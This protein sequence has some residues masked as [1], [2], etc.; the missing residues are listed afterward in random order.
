V[1]QLGQSK[2]KGTAKAKELPNIDAD[3]AVRRAVTYLKTAPVATEGD[4]GD[5]T[6]YKVACKLKDFGVGMVTAY[7]LMMGDWNSRCNPP[8]G[9]ELWEKIKH[10]YLYGQEPQGAAAPEAQFPPIEEPDQPEALHPF[11]K[12]NKE[13]A[14]VKKGAFVL[15]ETTDDTGAFVTEHLNMAEFHGWFA[16]KMFAA[17]NAKPKPI[18]ECWLSWAQRR[19]YEA[20]VFRPQEDVGPRWYNL[21]RGFSVEPAEHSDH[22]SVA[23]FKE[24][25]LNNV[26][27]GDEE[28]CHWLLGYF[29]HM[30]QKPWEKPL[31]A[32]VFKGKKGTGKNA[33]VERVGQLFSSH[34][35]VADD[36]RYLLSNFNSHLESN[37]FFVLDEASWAG[38]KR[39]EGKLKGMITGQ[40]HNIERKG[41]ESY[42]VK[43]LTRV[44]IIGNEDWLVPASAD[45]RRFAVFNVGDGR[46]QDRAF[47]E[48]MRTGMEQGGY[49]HLLKFLIDFN[50]S[51]VDVNDA[52]NTVGLMEQKIASLGPLEQWWHGCLESGQILCGDFGAEWPE[53]I[54][55]NRLH[56]ALERYFKKRNIKSRAPDRNALSRKLKAMAV[57]Y[58]KKKNA[59]TETGDATYAYFMPSIAVLRNDFDNYLGNTLEW[60]EL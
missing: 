29:A 21:W 2:P 19:E 56:D 22:P 55:I 7:E 48:Q 15:Q 38:D 4:A 8:W 26:C 36:E 50:L 9:D 13:F 57:H 17:G 20:V 41:K 5:L 25:A 6:T 3:R 32:L 40:H 60:E 1:K 47:F 30:I 39:A 45:E 18:S 24:H 54:P 43:N 59:K 53:R 27:G 49:S 12:L 11:D 14:F 23:A 52:P 58:T 10:A 35:L 16:N 44:A 31:V 34:F 42:K 33:L 51:G 28:L 46:R 37:L